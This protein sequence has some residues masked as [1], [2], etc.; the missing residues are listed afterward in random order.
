MLSVYPDLLGDQAPP[1]APPVMIE[2]LP[3]VKIHGE[4]GI[5]LV[6]FLSYLQKH[7]RKC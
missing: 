3:I 7:H 1:P 4:Q 2:S 5:N 6:P